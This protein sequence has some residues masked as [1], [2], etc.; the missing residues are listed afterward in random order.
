MLIYLIKCVH[1]EKEIH[2]KEVYMVDS[3]NEIIDFVD[4]ILYNTKQKYY[5]N[6]NKR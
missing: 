3:K 4:D 2:G 1:T 5:K 6:S